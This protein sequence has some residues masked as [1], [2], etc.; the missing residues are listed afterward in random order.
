M[1]TLF[2]NNSHLVRI[3]GLKDEDG[4]FINNADTVEATLLEADKQTEVTGVTWPVPL[5]Y[6][7]ET[8]GDYEG[9]LPSGLGVEEGARYYL[10]L[11][12]MVNGKRFE[13]TRTVK[14]E[15]RYG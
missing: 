7:G 5:Y 12:A 15:V 10:K 3:R 13:V 2:L 4:V 8:N 1:D 6:V 11:A 14:A 9:G